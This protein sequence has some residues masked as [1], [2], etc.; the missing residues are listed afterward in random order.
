MEGKR[1]AF[2]D[3]LVEY[4]SSGRMHDQ[5][6]KPPAPKQRNMTLEDP[7][8]LVTIQ[9]FFKENSAPNSI[10][11]S[12]GD[13]LQSHLPPQTVQQ[14]EKKQGTLKKIA[15]LVRRSSLGLSPSN[16]T[17]GKPKRDD[18]SDSRLE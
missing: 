18:Q 7:T 5:D 10:G 1:Q 16:S 14:E 4:S 13:S 8:G 15:G 11:G 9:D 6:S 3:D 12:H 2:I 17:T